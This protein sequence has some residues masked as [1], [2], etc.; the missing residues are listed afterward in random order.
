MKLVT[1]TLKLV[2]SLVAVTA[3]NIKKQQ[4][5]SL[6]VFGDS[7][8]D[9]GRLRTITMEMVPPPPY[10]QG[11]FSSGPVWSEYVAIL[12]NMQLRNYAVG[13]AVT[14]SSTLK[15]F[16]FLPLTIP[17]THDQIASAT[18]SSASVTPSASDIA[19]LEIGGN[20]I[21]TVLP[22]VVSGKTSAAAFANTLSNT[23]VAQVQMLATAGFR[24]ILV[25]NAP[26][27]QFVPLMKMERRQATA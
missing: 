25:A 7:I 17:S 20:D 12:R 10:W 2:L 9:T 4:Q 11:R 15:L 1:L 19:V 23:V 14:S 5:A 6:Y 21:M 24:T 18:A 3:T 13:A 26:P 27:M 8:S 22:N 16:G